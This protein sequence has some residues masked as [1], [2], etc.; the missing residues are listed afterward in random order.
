MTSRAE[1]T[2]FFVRHT[3]TTWNV[4]SRYQ[5][6]ID[7]PLS[8]VGRDQVKEI[9]RH[10]QSGDF[11]A[12]FSSPL[13][14][15]RVL[16]ESMAQASGADVVVDE[17][18]TEIAMGPWEGLTRAEIES[19]F[20]EMLRTWHT[21]PELVEFPG[22]E[23][24]GAVSRR[25]GDFLTERFSSPDHDRVAVVSHDVVVKVAIMRGLGLD[26]R[27]LHA[28]RMRNGSVSVLRGWTLKG[29]VESVGNYSHLTG[30]PFQLPN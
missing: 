9:T 14:R 19:R 27:N 21:R 22:A 7:A 3:Q 8:E 4:E 2:L 5:G 10:V 25:V 30:S 11:G 13:T 23:T 29:S 12:V 15:A 16:A 20:G 18:L 24:L 17:R 6:R 28:F 1:H 26:L